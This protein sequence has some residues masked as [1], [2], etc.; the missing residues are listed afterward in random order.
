MEEND[1]IGYQ[2][3]STCGKWHPTA[4]SYAGRFCSRECAKSFRKC[5]VCGAYFE[6]K[7][8]TSDGFCSAECAG[9]DAKDGPANILEMASADDFPEPA[10]DSAEKT[11]TVLQG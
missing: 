7:E 10:A 8:S 5:P 6:M 9:V 2:R 1:P 4:G 11:E 3:C